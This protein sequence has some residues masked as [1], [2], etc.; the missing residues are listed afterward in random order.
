MEVLNLESIKRIIYIF[1]LLTCC[2]SAIAQDVQND[3][4]F[5]RTF[6]TADYR[7]SE[8]NYSIAEDENGILFIANENGIL[9]FDGSTWLLHPLPDYSHVITVKMGPDGRLYVGGD[10]EF[11][12]MVRD[13]TGAMNFTSLRNLISQETELDAVWQI[14]FDNGD[15]YFQTYEAII[16]YDGEIGHEL[17]IKNGWLFKLGDEIFVSVIEEGIAKLQ[18]DT[19]N[20]VNR[21][22]KFSEDNPMRPLGQLGSKKILPTEFNGLFLFDTIT[23]ETTKWEVPASNELS[24]A[25]IY[26]ATEWDEDLFMFSTMKGGLIWIDKKGD[27]V[28]RLNKENGLKSLETRAFHRDSKGNLWLPGYGVHHLIW[29]QKQKLESFATII[30]SVEI[31]E[32]GIQINSNNRSMISP[33]DGSVKFLAIHFATPGFDKTDLQYSYKLVGFDKEWSSWTNNSFKQYTNIPPGEYTFHVKA[34]LANGKIS[35][36][37]K[38]TLSIDAI[39]YQSDWLKVAG[40]LVVWF[41]IMGVYRFRTNQLKNYNRRLEEIVEQRTSELRE[42]NEL[43]IVKNAELDQFV[44]RV[45]HDLV[46][47]LKSVKALMSITQEETDP[48]EQE[49]CFDMMKLSLDKQEEFVKRMLDQAVNYRDVKKEPVELNKI[50]NTVFRDHKYY[51]GGNKMRF[52]LD[53]PENFTVLADPDRIKIV[54]NNLVSNAIK[55]RKLDE[56]ESYISLKATQDGNKAII[57]VA[58][59]GLGIEEKFVAKIFDMF[60]RVT[61]QS[62]G[63]GLGLYIVK[64]MMTKMDG[65]I[66]VESEFG[67]GTTFTLTFPVA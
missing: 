42:A 61:E 43:L 50:C 47:P 28:K 9:E 22:I 35:E 64:D 38:L 51:E 14:M 2:I 37:A 33:V 52:D 19:L 65:T 44:R 48:A 7:A 29:P 62:H 55:Y 10:N 49:K 26:D 30:R 32:E 58:D 56:E 54:L 1:W 53:C 25:E 31:N 45:S 18:D 67:K 36:V 66:E 13:S 21:D 11:G 41:L 24:K 12:Y 5:I 39:W 3:S 57:T 15:T 16:K 60:V 59:N 34:R 27:V 20:F 4:L 46:A 17:P 63:S 8:F 6:G 40:G 23:Y